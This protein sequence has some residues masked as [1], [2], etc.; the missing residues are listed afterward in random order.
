MTS[1]L[2]LLAALLLAP[3]DGPDLPGKRIDLD[4][5]T[6]FLPSGYRPHAGVV[7]LV[8]H[9]HGAPGVVEPAILASG[10]PA[11]LIEFNRKGLSRVYTEPFSD[12]ALLPHLIDRALAAIKAEGLASNPREGTLVVSSF[13]AGFGGVREILKVPQHFDRIDAIVMADSLYAGY[14]GDPTQ[15]EVDPRLMAGFARFAAEAAEGRKTFLLT[16]SAQVPEGY[17]STTETADFLIRSLGG[18]PELTKVDWGDGWTQVRRFSKGR[19]LVLGF[20]GTEG[21]DHLRHLRAIAQI[22]KAAPDPF[23]GDQ[24]CSE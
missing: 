24:G 18:M 21:S 2:V 8:L 7:N 13:S 6:L 9:L 11:A 22:W 20:H 23:A 19:F 1:L 15:H 10:W 3:V 14:A 4:G 5:A 17:A 16:H 12:P